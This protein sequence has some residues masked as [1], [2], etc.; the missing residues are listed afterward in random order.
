MDFFSRRRVWLTSAF[1]I[2]SAA[3]L[4]L[5]ACTS[6]TTNVTAPTTS[7]CAVTATSSIDSAPAGG[8]DATVNVDTTRDCI[9]SASTSTSWITLGGTTTGQG[10]G[11]VDARIAANPSPVGRSGAV[12]VNGLSVAISQAAAPCT[13]SVAPAN[14][15]INPAGGSVTVQVGTIAGCAWTSSSGISWL[16]VTGGGNGPGS[17]T[18]AAAANGGSI[19]SGSVT[20]AGQTVTI[21]QGAP[22]P[23]PPA[24]NPVPTPNPLPACT[25]AV[26]PASHDFGAAGAVFSV[27]LTTASTCA[28]TVHSNVAWVVVVGAASGSGDATVALSAAPNTGAARAGTVTIGGQTVSVTQDALA[29]PCNYTLSPKSATFTQNAGSGTV[30][31]TAGQAC[32]WTATPDA[33]W[34]AITSGVSGIGSGTVRYT[35]SA[36]SDKKDRHGT[37]SVADQT[38][39]IAQGGTD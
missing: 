10:S 18:V 15:A 23:L 9:W 36:N 1:A 39:A 22:T 3:A 32:A 19:R 30:T 34:V 20:I 16:T 25:Y 11:S 5:A 13:Y 31:V 8:A 26:S 37:I 14:A 24:P 33:S 17:A 38:F 7:K 2:V 6:S 12:S 28:W 29:P 21:T 4:L 27:A 35:V